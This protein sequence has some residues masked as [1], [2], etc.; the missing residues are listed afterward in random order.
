[1]DGWKSRYDKEGQ[2]NFDKL[3]GRQ[4]HVQD[5]FWRLGKILLVALGVTITYV[6]ITEDL[7]T[8]LK[9]FFELLK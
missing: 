1:M 2:S 7:F 6:L 4:L 9:S 5:N 3:A 8:G